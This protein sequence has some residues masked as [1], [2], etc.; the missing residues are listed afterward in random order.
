LTEGAVS[1][2]LALAVVTTGWAG[3][4][5][6]WPTASSCPEAAAV[7]PGAGASRAEKEKGRR[8][9]REGK[10]CH[11]GI[12]ALR[13]KQSLHGPWGGGFLTEFRY[14]LRV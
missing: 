10:D 5:C 7:S 1:S 2:T 9:R 13:V 6:V 4:A 8:K 14:R 12:E 3:K 11:V